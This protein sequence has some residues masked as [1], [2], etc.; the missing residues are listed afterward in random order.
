MRTFEVKPVVSILNTF[1]ATVRESVL[2]VFNELRQ[3][4]DFFAQQLYQTSRSAFTRNLKHAID[5]RDAWYQ[6]K[7]GGT[8]VVQGLGG[9]WVG[10]AV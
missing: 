6:D 5:L 8:R 9:G 10:L 1:T 3:Q 7:V 4:D 2:A